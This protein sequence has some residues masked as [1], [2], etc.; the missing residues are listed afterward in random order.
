MPT[1]EGSRRASKDSFPGDLL[2]VSEVSGSDSSPE[3]GASRIDVCLNLDELIEDRGLH[4]NDA[5]LAL[6][7]QK[8]T[9]ATVSTW[10]FSDDNESHLAP[11][12]LFVK[13]AESTESQRADALPEN[14]K[15]STARRLADLVLRRRAPPR[16]PI[17]PAPP[18]Q[19]SLAADAPS[20]RTLAS[21][22]RSQTPNCTQAPHKSD[23]VKGRAG[24]AL[25]DN[26]VQLKEVLGRGCSLA[27]TNSVLCENLCRVGVQ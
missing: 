14:P 17:A 25:L 1:E 7:R 4:A 18:A 27:S 6:A 10:S 2:N 19:T 23:V 16:A 12:C 9:D 24:R 26:G 3:P 5:T 20:L 15:K 22:P 21:R 8:R 13:S 11:R